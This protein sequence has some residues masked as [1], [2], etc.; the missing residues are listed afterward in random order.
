[1]KHAS[2]FDAPFWLFL[3]TG[4]VLSAMLA[5]FG[6]AAAAQ[7]VSPGGVSVMVVDDS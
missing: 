2:R 7:D 5:C 6:L 3:A 4:I 1:M